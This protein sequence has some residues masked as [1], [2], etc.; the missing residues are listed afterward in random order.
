MLV[1][2]TLTV[3]EDGGNSFTI[4]VSR[5]EFPGGTDMWIVIVK[6][7]GDDNIVDWR[8]PVYINYDVVVAQLESNRPFGVYP[9]LARLLSEAVRR[10]GA[11]FNDSP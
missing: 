2:H 9:H 8:G 3:D 1:T 4:A 6:E 10:C 5:D 7:E 11:M